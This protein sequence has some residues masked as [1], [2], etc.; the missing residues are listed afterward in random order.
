[1]EYTKEGFMSLYDQWSAL[2]QEVMMSN[3]SFDK[4]R[5]KAD[6]LEELRIQIFKYGVELVKQNPS[7]KEVVCTV[8]SAFNLY[9]PRIYNLIS[10][11]LKNDKLIA[12]L[13]LKKFDESAYGNVGDNLKSDKEVMY[14]QTKQTSGLFAITEYSP[15]LRNDP[16]FWREIFES[17]FIALAS[18]VGDQFG[19]VLY[20]IDRLNKKYDLHIDMS[21]VNTV[22]YEA[23]AKEG[24]NSSLD[25]MGL[26]NSGWA[27][28]PHIMHEIMIGNT[29]VINQ[30]VS[31]S[32]LKNSLLAVPYISEE[33]KMSI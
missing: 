5:P 19:K 26:Y 24:R 31:D 23:Q 28:N 33:D 14:L 6:K 1:M 4:I 13:A 30:C 29:E 15:E 10:D 11:E 27:Y 3:V 25:V 8:Y 7:D 21:M 2:N 32:E 16:S 18:E 17:R 20:E 9:A 22:F 12:M